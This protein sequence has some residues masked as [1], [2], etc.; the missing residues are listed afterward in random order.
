MEETFRKF[1]EGD[2]QAFGDLFR[3]LFD[4]ARRFLDTFPLDAAIAN[5]ILQETF[6][7]IWEKHRRFDDEL[8]LMAYL[9]KSLRNNSVKYIL[10]DRRQRPLSDMYPSTDEEALSAIINIEVSRAVAEAVAV[11]PEERRNVIRLSMAG[12]TVEQIAA[13]L[14]ISVNTVKTL[15]KRAYNSLRENLKDI[16]ILTTFVP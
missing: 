10:R 11:L 4:P 3:R 12:M 1:K 2:E 14:G 13:E 7:R 8:H 5:D 6:F 15:K 9:Y 16:K